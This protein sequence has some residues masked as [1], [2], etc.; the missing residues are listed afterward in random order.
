[1]EA[2]V[3]SDSRVMKN[4]A[5]WRFV[6]RHKHLPSL[7]LCQEKRVRH[8]RFR[9]NVLD[10]VVVDDGNAFENEWRSRSS[11]QFVAFD[12]GNLLLLFEILLLSYRYNQGRRI[13]AY[14]G[15][16][17]LSTNSSRIL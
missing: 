15:Q 16:F 2:R 13:N 9:E 1:M 14:F 11:L 3:F 12:C 6:P 4:A 5:C 10:E 8:R 7:R 17:A